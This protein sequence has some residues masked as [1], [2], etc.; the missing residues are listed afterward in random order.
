MEFING[1]TTV[2]EGGELPYKVVLNGGTP[3]AAVLIHATVVGTGCSLMPNSVTNE[4]TFTLSTTVDSLDYRLDA[5][6]YSCVV[7]HTVTTSD[8]NYKDA[9]KL[10]YSI[11]VLSKGCGAGEYLGSKDR[12]GDVC[13]CSEDFF[14]PPQQDCKK[15]PIDSSVCNT[16]GLSAPVV[17]TG[18]WR[19][20][21]TS[22]DLETQPFYPC[23]FEGSCLGGNGTKGRCAKGFDDNGTLCATCATGY[24]LQGQTCSPCPGRAGTSIFSGTLFAVTFVGALAFAGGT[25]YTLSAPALTKSDLKSLKNTLKSMDN[26]DET[27]K[28]RARVRRKTFKRLV[29]RQESTVVLSEAQIDQAYDA[30]RGRRA[31]SV[32]KQEWDK[33]VHNKKE[34]MKEKAMEVKEE[35]DS[36][37]EVSA[38][39]N[40]LAPKNVQRMWSLT[41]PILAPIED[42][43]ILAKEMLQSLKN[44]VQT[45]W[46]Q[47]LTSVMLHCKS[48]GTSW[49]NDN[50]FFVVWPKDMLRTFAQ[51]LLEP[52]V[53]FENTVMKVQGLLKDIFHTM[54]HRMK[55]AT[56][57]RKRLNELMEGLRLQMQTL[58]TLLE[59]M[60][61]AFQPKFHF[62]ELAFHFQADRSHLLEVERLWNSVCK[63]ICDAIEHHLPPTTLMQLPASLLHFALITMPDMFEI[64]LKLNTEKFGGWYTKL[65]IFL[66]HA[67]C[68]TYF[69]VTFVGIAWPSNLKNFMKFWE[70]TSLDIFAVFGDMSC[71]MQTGYLQKFIFHMLLCP[72]MALI[73]FAVYAVLQKNRCGK[74]DKYT[75]ES[76]KSQLYSFLSLIAFTLYTGLATRIFRLFKCYNVQGT[77]YLMGDFTVTCFG[78][79][80]YAHAYIAI[81]CMVTYVFG[82]PF[83]QLYVLYTNRFN[84]HVETCT[85]PLLQNKLHKQYGSI[86]AAYRPE[87]YYFDIAD[88]IHRLLLTG[89]LILL[90]QD[91]VAQTFLGIVIC[92]IWQSTLL[93]LRPYAADWDNTIAI[94][95]AVQLQLTMVSGM[96][97]QLYQSTPAQDEYEQQGFA[98]VLLV[99]AA[100][101]TV[102][103]I[104][105][106][107]VGTPC[108]QNAWEKWTQRQEEKK[109]D[110]IQQKSQKAKRRWSG[111]NPNLSGVGAEATLEM[112]SNPITR[113]GNG[114]NSPLN[115]V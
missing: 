108:I 28:D 70:I 109:R 60:I 81:F 8:V 110:R 104:G 96:A 87:C 88:L 105:S 55:N 10:E 2:K 24:V 84:L 26:M 98:A 94:I 56:A 78:P 59:D 63:S 35:V 23:P 77:F 101:V 7:T 106:T 97:L 49:P 47:F 41:V 33:F 9:R 20:D 45:S 51:K 36:I 46:Q 89:G 76:L 19:D 54:K 16:R 37:A 25:Y 30:V 5:L 13:I 68:F 112:V 79:E 44:H 31:S 75:A 83:V 1:R 99:V 72:I 27:F 14:L 34:K 71:S 93:Y 64:N 67:Q 29:S 18:F 95:L 39:L 52:F 114:R 73:I 48:S 40:E 4:G 102:L 103:S 90:G 74:R 12:N 22:P 62:M 66:S 50:F 6:S 86:Y 3:S 82:I 11:S 38:A 100:F 32:G 57:L 111:V 15:C 85:D 115:H 113:S 65:K 107:L 69:P 43:S 53:K 91:S 92:A 80:W 61:S 58:E 42:F 21:P 17:K